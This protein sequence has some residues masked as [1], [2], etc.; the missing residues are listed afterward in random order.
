MS[1]RGIITIKL[2]LRDKHASELNR[3]AR[4]VNFVW[5]YCNEVQQK[6]AQSGR[7]WLNKF[8]LGALTSGSSKE[9][10]LHSH[11][12]QRVCRQFDDNRRAKKKPWLRWRGRRSL[13]WVPFSVGHVTFDGAAF[14]FRGVHPMFHDH[15]LRPGDFS[16]LRVCLRSTSSPAIL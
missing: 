5:N 8:D 10:D 4:A 14:R 3:Q 15:D 1:E 12:I 16:S 7:R 2:R 9:L 13:G 11:T 6:A